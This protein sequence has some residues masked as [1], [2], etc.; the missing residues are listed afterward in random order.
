M[1]A[2][3]IL[4]TIDSDAEPGMLMRLSPWPLPSD[5]TVLRSHLC[6]FMTPRA[7]SSHVVE[8][9]HALLR[10]CSPGLNGHAHD[11]EHTAQR[12]QLCRLGYGLWPWPVSV[13]S[14][15]F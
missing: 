8:L 3:G 1:R 15:A 11:S 9:L 5:D 7:L 14:V 4:E 2:L 12:V 13:R 10:P 6:F